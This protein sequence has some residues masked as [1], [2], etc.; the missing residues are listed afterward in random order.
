MF[1]SL[2]GICVFVSAI[3][4]L[5]NR[6]TKEPIAETE[7]KQKTAAIAQV[8]PGFDNQPLEEAFQFALPG[9]EKDPLTFYPAKAGDELIGYAIET[10]T[11][12][13]F[14]G[15]IRFMVGI[16]TAGV[17]KDFSV[18]L[19]NETPGLGSKIPD[20]F[21]TPAKEGHVQDVRNLSLKEHAPLAVTK[22]GGKVDAISAATISSRA[23]LDALNR[24]YE[25]Y[26]QV[27]NSE[28]N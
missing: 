4:A 22:D 10:F 3:L 6:L 28:K 21:K 25:A 15:E 20:F 12:K 11:K 14:S 18:L 24:A 7:L 9:E 26:K 1:L 17:L 19:T 2:V 8:M 5:L 27:R 16:D 23:F 13:G